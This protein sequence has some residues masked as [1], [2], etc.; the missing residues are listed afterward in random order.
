MKKS[1]FHGY[2]QPKLS[3]PNNIVTK[4]TDDQKK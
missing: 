3:I 1:S 2:Y 4:K